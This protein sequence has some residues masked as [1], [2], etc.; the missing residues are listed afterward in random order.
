MRLLIN[1]DVTQVVSE[2]WSVEV[3][4]EVNIADYIEAVREDPSIIHYPKG[5]PD[6]IGDA[7]LYDSEVYDDL[8]SK[9]VSVNVVK[10]YVN[11]K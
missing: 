11:G 3:S 5:H 7:T 2:T 4:D 9:L 8:S 6:Q 10:G 1:M